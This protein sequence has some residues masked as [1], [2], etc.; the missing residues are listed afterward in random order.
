MNVKPMNIIAGITAVL[1][2]IGGIFTFDAR[3]AKQTDFDTKI[4]DIKN[5]II[6]E[7]RREVVKNRSVMINAMQREADDL[8]YQMNVLERENK[9]IP[10]YM[11][12]KHKQILRQIEELQNNDKED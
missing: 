2:L 11:S 1:G 8:E 10:R 9:N 6:D 3:Y 5:E 4:T 12:D 7:M